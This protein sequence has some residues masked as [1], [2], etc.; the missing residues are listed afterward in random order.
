MILSNRP[1]FELPFASVSKRVLVRNHSDGNLFRLH[2]QSFRLQVRFPFYM[3]RFETEPRGNSE[4]A[5]IVSHVL[6]PVVF[7]TWSVD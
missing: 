6:E 3:T 1:L 2:V 4:M 5:Y 7:V